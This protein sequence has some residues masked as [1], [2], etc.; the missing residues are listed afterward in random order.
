MNRIGGA[1]F[2]VHD[3]AAARSALQHAQL[4]VVAVRDIVTVRLDQER[5]GQLG[6]LCGRMAAKPA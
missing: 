6:A 5:P 2:L 1:H 3:G 4:R